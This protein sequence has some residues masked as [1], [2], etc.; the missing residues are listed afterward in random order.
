MSIRLKI[1]GKS[2][3]VLED[4][5]LDGFLK[6]HPN[7]TIEKPPTH[8]E[9]IRRFKNRYS[10]LDRSRLSLEYQRRLNRGAKDDLATLE[11]VAESLDRQIKS[12]QPSDHVDPNYSGIIRQI[13]RSRG[14]P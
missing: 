4:D 14:Q 8:E 1:P 2:P 9:R 12:E 11:R 5:A 13:R 7:L 6:E 3:I 10:H